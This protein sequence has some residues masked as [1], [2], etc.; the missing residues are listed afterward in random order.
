MILQNLVFFR[1]GEV[2]P[3]NKLSTPPL[4]RKRDDMKDL[5]GLFAASQRVV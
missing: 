5:A 2:F 1:G 3:T 4:R